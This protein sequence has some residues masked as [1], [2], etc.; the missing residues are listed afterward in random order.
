MAESPGVEELIH[1]VIDAANARDFEA[2]GRLPFHPEFEF[3]SLFSTSEG[4]T[5]VGIEGLRTWTEEVDSVWDEFRVEVE[6]VWTA[7]EDRAAVAM[8]LTGRARASGVPLDQRTGQIWT[9]RD[10]LLFTSVGYSS[11]DEALAEL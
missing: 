11:P 6:Q 8:R 4:V 7:G 5:L 9:R 3:H 1:Q 10:G 2:L